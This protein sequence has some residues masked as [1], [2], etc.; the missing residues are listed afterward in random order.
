MDILENKMQRSNYSNQE[1]VLIQLP[2]TT[3]EELAYFEE[4]LKEVNFKEEAVQYF[5]N[6]FFI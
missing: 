4:Q 2:I 3:F 6:I 1:E 5:K